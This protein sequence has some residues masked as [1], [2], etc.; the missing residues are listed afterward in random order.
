MFRT[1]SEHV[2]CDSHLPAPPNLMLGSSMPMA[3]EAWCFFGGGCECCGLRGLMLLLLTCSQ[4]LSEHWLPPSHADLHI[5][6]EEDALQ[7]K[8]EAVAARPHYR[9]WNALAQVRRGG[10]AVRAQT[11]H[12]MAAQCWGLQCS[13]GQAH[14]R[15]PPVQVPGPVVAWT[16]KGCMHA[17]LIRDRWASASI[18]RCCLIR[19]CSCSHPLPAPRHG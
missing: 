17:G 2:G 5:E 10:G 8:R 12:G 11:Q 4:R 18:L 13:A 3:V 14:S 1:L 19:L 16:L 6:T 15:M 9:V 7:R